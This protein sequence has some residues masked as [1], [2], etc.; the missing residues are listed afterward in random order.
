ML[1]KV[2]WTLFPALPIL[3]WL[4][5]K[6][7]T[8]WVKQT[9]LKL[10]WGLIIWYHQY[11]TNVLTGQLLYTSFWPKPAV[12]DLVEETVSPSQSCIP[13]V[14]LTLNLPMWWW[15]GWRRG[16]GLQYLISFGQRG[17]LFLFSRYKKVKLIHYFA[18]WTRCLFGSKALKRAWLLVMHGPDDRYQQ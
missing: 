14:K 4:Q 2:P 15:L 6:T 3:I 13:I 10:A 17:Y 16:A 12:C 11:F 8:S 9:C 5:F 1:K 18:A 7:I